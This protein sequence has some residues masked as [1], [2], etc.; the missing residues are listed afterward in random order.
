MWQELGA[1][2]LR[3]ICGFYSFAEY[4]GW[5]LGGCFCLSDP[6]NEGVVWG[7]NVDIEAGKR[8]IFGNFWWK[9]LV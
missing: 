3:W 5:G 8:R 7:A 1:L 2:G 4:N 6:Y 9:F